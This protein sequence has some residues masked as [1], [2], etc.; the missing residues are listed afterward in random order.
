MLIKALAPPLS[1]DPDQ[2]PTLTAA[3]TQMGVIMGTAAYISPEQARGKVVDKRADIWTFGVVLY[4]MLT[5]AWKVTAQQFRHRRRVGYFV[6]LGGQQA[7]AEVIEEPVV[8]MPRSDPQDVATFQFLLGFLRDLRE[9][10]RQLAP[11]LLSFFLMTAD[12]PY[13]ESNQE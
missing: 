12:T 1:A 5:V 10:L 2:S 11:H 13:M 4:E 3:A 9:Y 6:T 7:I 8:G